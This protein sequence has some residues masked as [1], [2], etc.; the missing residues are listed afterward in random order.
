[1]SATK[2][3][4]EYGQYKTGYGWGRASTSPKNRMIHLV[5]LDLG[6]TTA[7]CGKGTLGT[8][9]EFTTGN[10]CPECAEILGIKNAED[11]DT[12]EEELAWWKAQ[13]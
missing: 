4:V 10:L 1:M 8:P 3:P 7:V 13:Q 11:F 12:D 6:N 9:G 5:I 2:I